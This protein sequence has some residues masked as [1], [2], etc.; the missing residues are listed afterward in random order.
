MR[1]NNSKWNHC[2]RINSQ[3]IHAAHTTQ[4]QKNKQP[5]HK[6]WKRPKQTFLQKDIQMAN[7]HMKNVQH[8]SLLE[9]CKSKLQWDITSQLSEWPSSKSLQTISAG[10]GVKKREHFC[11]FGGNVNWYSHYGKWHEDSLKIL[12]IELPY[13]PAIPLLGIHTKETRFER[14]TCTPMF[15]TALFIVVVFIETQRDRL[16]FRW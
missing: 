8:H 2:Q 11:I 5:N 13:I 12:E 9:K 3:N 15:I 6:I 4:Y 1:E 10:K 7:K 14:D 16:L